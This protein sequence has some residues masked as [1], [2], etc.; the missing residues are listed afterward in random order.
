MLKRIHINQ[1]HIRANRKDG[2]DRPVIT[3]KTYR[4]NDYGH[5]V[6]IN[7]PSQVVYSPEKPLS[8]GATV[9]VETRA[10]VEIF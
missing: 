2:G 4:S 3:V 1:H 9:W 6:E 7:G 8:C 5:R 10:D